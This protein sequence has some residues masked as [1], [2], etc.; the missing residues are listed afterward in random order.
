MSTRAELEALARRWISLWCV[1]VDWKLFGALH[2]DDFEDGSSAN[3]PPTKQGF[4]A[5]LAELVHAFPD[6]QTRVEALVIDENAGSI[7]VRWSARGENHAAFLG[8]GPTRRRTTITGI[9]IIEVRAGRIQ[10]RWG[11]WDVSD[12]RETP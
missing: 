11:E 12:H 4:A 3:R 8:I 2:A 9:E 10:R 1:P 7:A 5:G 6:L